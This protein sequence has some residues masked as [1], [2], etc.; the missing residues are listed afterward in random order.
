MNDKNFEQA[1]NEILIEQ[2]EQ[3]SDV[4]I[5][6]KEII[7][8]F[9]KF[10]FDK[11]SK[12]YNNEKL[13]LTE[14][15]NNLLTTATTKWLNYRLPAFLL[16]NPIDFEFALA[17]ISVLGSKLIIIINEKREYNNSNSRK[18]RERENNI[19]ETDNKQS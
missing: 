4:Q 15:E 1:L 9:Y 11:L 10:I 6:D 7:S 2:K 5:I 17:L 13:K 19:S 18:E 14:E 8:L 3:G 16:R 12:I